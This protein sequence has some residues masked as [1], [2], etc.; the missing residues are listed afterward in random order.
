[1]QDIEGLAS[2]FFI[3]FNSSYIIAT[4]LTIPFTSIGLNAPLII[5][6]MNSNI[7]YMKI[8]SY[9]VLGLAG[10]IL[11]GSIISDKMIGVE[12][13]NV[14]QIVIFTKLLYIQN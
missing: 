8:A 6:K 5:S 1:L 3:G 7:K 11:I 10:I 13:I 12:T 9:V 14:L 4:N 2:G